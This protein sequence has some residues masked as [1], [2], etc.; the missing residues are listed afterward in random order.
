MSIAAEKATFKGAL[1]HPL[2]GRLARPQGKAR[3]YALF[4]HCFTCSKDTLA[5]ARIASAL[6]ARGIAVLRFDF[7]GLG[8]SEGEFGNTDFS[9]NVADLVAAA[10]WLRTTHEAPQLLVGHSL[11]GAAVLA[12]ASR[13]PEAKAIATIAA[14]SGPEHLRR[15]FTSSAEQIERRGEAE[16]EIAGRR[17]TVTKRFLDDISSH[18]LKPAIAALGR[19]LLVFH[20]PRDE[21]VG[22]ENAT[23]IFLAAK[24]P[25]SFISL[26]DAD[27]LLTRRADA[28]FVADVVAAWAGRYL[29]PPLA[30]TAER[31]AEG[32][33]LV[34]EAGMGRFTQEVLAGNHMFYADEPVSAG[35]DDAGP[36]PYQ[37]LSAALGTC[38]SMTVRLY[39]ARKGMPL[40]RVQVRVSHD[41]VHAQ[42]CAECETREGLVDEF[43]RTIT[44]DG[45]LDAAQTAKLLE[46]ADKCPVH[47][48]LHSEI[49]VKTTLG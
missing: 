45:P 11:G 6:S 2:S 10:D 7:T 22:I 14:P 47:R 33:V 34:R 41:K 23:E 40:E 18:N 49:V 17:F 19:A 39:A 32:E 29:T 5:A 31:L 20:G 46:I 42:D 43:R 1:G 37:L 35:G 12:A 8:D 26:D 16:V 44:L 13:I 25:K 27:H 9:S 15:L 3:A 30:G 36:G 21:V 28:V 4:A 48:T 24:H 38:T